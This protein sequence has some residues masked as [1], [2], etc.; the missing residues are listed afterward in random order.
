[1]VVR[2]YAQ[3][4]W[5]GGAGARFET[6]DADLKPRGDKDALRCSVSLL[7]PSLDRSNPCSPGPEIGLVL[8]TYDFANAN[9]L[10]CFNL[11]TLSAPK[12]SDPS[13]LNSFFSLTSYLFQHAHRTSRAA[14]YTYLTLFILQILVEDQIL[15]KRLSSD[16]SAMSVRLCRQ[17]HPYLPVVKGD[18]VPIAIILDLLVD[19]INHNLKKRLDVEYYM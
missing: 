15:V 19:G 10:F 13:P 16:E 1:M 18:R 2:L 8:S 9:K 11:V 14:L 4:A 17:R 12:K 6:E 3:P 7:L 5:A